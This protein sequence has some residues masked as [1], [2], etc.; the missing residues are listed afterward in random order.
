MKSFWVVSTPEGSGVSDPISETV[1]GRS[2]ATIRPVEEL[3]VPSPVGAQVLLSVRACALSRIPRRLINPAIEARYPLG[4]E[5]SGVVLET[6]PETKRIRKG[7]EV[8]GILPTDTNSPGCATHLLISEM[9]L[10][11]KPESLSHPD[12]CSLLS[13]GMQAYTAL[14]LLGHLQKD[15]VIL[16]CDGASPAALLCIQLAHAHCTKIIAT[17]CS[18]EE[19]EQLR[20]RIPFPITVIDVGTQA[21]TA[22]YACLKETGGMGV[23]LIIDFGIKMDES[24]VQH[25][26]NSEYIE[27]SNRYAPGILDYEHSFDFREDCYALSLFKKKIGLTKSQVLSCLSPGG[28]WVT[29]QDNLQLDPPDTH[30]LFMKGATLSFLFS[31]IWGLSGYN[32]GKYL[33]IVSSLMAK[34]EANAIT[35]SKYTKIGFE[36]ITDDILKYFSTESSSRLIISI[37]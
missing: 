2:A 16:V 8:V 7:Q 37:N 13:P 6:G 23:N 9:F 28:R 25:I 36:S 3:L 33:H 14:H 4:H 29:S 24:L 22:S 11:P 5:V 30:A 1:P 20:D 15:D 17:V 27:N 32:Q 18:G 26:K 21:K 35:P 34:L 12:C 19:A 31:D 10:V